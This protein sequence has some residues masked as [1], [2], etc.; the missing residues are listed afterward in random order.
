[1]AKNDDKKNKESNSNL[2]FFLTN[3]NDF[4]YMDPGG[5]IMTVGVG[6]QYY[7]SPEQKQS[8]KYDSKTDIYSLGIIIFEM[9]YKF[10]SLKFCRY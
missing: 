7:C 4:Q 10:N 1:M 8:N 5:E 3:F 6:T 9:F 2:N